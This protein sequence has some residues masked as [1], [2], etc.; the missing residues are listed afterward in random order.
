MLL[1]AVHIAVGGEPGDEDSILIPL[2]KNFKVKCYNYSYTVYWLL[3]FEGTT[4]L[5]IGHAEI[6]CRNKFYGVRILDSNTHSLLATLL[7]Q[8]LR[9]LVY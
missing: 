5:W 9:L 6:F 3:K 2:T 1:Y 7:Y 8:T 4:F